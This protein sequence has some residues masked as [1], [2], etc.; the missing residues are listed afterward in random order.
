MKNHRFCRGSVILIT[1]LFKSQL[2]IVRKIREI[3][4]QIDRLIDR[5]TD[6]DIDLLLLLFL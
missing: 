2:Q 6:A 4:R 3:D 5:Q 1:M